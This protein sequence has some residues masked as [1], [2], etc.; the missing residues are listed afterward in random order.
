M[1]SNVLPYAPRDETGIYPQLPQHDFRMQKFN[2]FTASLNAEVVHYKSVAK[3]YKRAKKV[4]NWSA[5][6]LDL[7]KWVTLEKMGYVFKK[8]CTL[9]K[10]AIFNKID[11]IWRNVC[12]R[13]KKLVK[14]KE[15][16]WRNASHL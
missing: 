11:H 14:L 7:K 5:A 13:L 4:T 1:S 8:W 12:S 10:L 16:N 2:E 6:G 3:K 15:S 9:E